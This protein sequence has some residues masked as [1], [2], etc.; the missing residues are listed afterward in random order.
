MTKTRYVKD[1]RGKRVKQRYQ[2]KV[3]IPAEGASAIP[4]RQAKSAFT[5]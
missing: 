2:E 4:T 5:L 1:K 3:A